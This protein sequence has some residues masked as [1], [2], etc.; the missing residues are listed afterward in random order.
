MTF[1]KSDL[2]RVICCGLEALKCKCKSGASPSGAAR[3]K[4][5]RF[6]LNAQTCGHSADFILVFILICYWV[7]AR[8]DTVRLCLW[9]TYIR[10][11]YILKLL[12]DL[13]SPPSPIP[14]GV[15]AAVLHDDGWYS[16]HFEAAGFLSLVDHS[17]D[18]YRW[19]V[20]NIPHTRPFYR[21]RC[22]QGS[23]R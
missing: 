19:H 13:L 9:N 12:I 16:H 23:W 22:S 20:D 3:T 18:Y 17:Y 21:C 15:F 6:Y 5:M 7:M 8:P 11:F 1:A 10:F 14:L 2:I 4:V